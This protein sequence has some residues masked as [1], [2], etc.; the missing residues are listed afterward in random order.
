MAKRNR[1]E[2]KVVPS[3]ADEREARTGMR[4]SKGAMIA[5]I[6]LGGMFLAVSLDRSDGNWSISY[7][8][9]CLVLGGG[10]IAWGLL[11]Y[12]EARRKHKEAEEAKKAARDAKILSVPLEKFS[13]RNAGMAESLA[14]KYDTAF[15]EERAAEP[16]LDID[17]NKDGKLDWRDAAVDQAVIRAGKESLFGEKGGPKD[18]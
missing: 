14:E 17:W 8:L 3:R 16:V 7:F 2:R 9:F 15:A 13:D 11:P 6:V 5:K 18:A 1:Y 12:L 4:Q 10:L